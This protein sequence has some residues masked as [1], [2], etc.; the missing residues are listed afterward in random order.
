MTSTDTLRLS[1]LV[2]D[3]LLDHAVEG[4][5]RDP[6]E[7]VCG[8]LVGGR[9]PD[10]ATATRRV[11]N[12]A[13]HPRSRYELDPEATMAAVDAVEADGDEVVG[14]YHSHPESAP[15]PSATDRARATWTGYVYAI[16]SPPDA[17]RA[18]RYTGDG[19]DELAVQVEDDSRA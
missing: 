10:R 13:D 5:D 9:A 8:V 4:A 6:P 2:R 19:F 3:A 11:P 16:V 15:V 14:F 18:Y 17:I 12:V 1:S 7:E